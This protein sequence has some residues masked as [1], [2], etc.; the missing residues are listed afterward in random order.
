MNKT[1]GFTAEVS[2]YSPTRCYPTAKAFLHIDVAVY[3][4]QSIIDWSNMSI[5]R[6][7]PYYYFEPGFCPP[8]LRPVRVKTGGQ[9]CELVTIPYY[10]PVTGK[11]ETKQATIC[12]FEPIGYRWECQ[13]PAFTVLT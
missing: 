8:G 12:H 13:L 5:N 9:V 4:A 2:L 11:I 3:P 1:P 10:N 6:G 7:G